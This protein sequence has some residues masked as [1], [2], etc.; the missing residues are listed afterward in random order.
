MYEAHRL[1]GMDKNLTYKGLEMMRKHIGWVTSVVAF[2]FILADSVFAAELFRVI[3]VR[4]GPVEKPAR[5]FVSISLDRIKA[6]GAEVFTGARVTIL[7]MGDPL[8]QLAKV[9]E[10]VAKLK[11]QLK[12][13]KHPGVEFVSETV[14]PA[15]DERG[16]AS[17]FL[18]VV[19]K[20][21]RSHIRKDESTEVV[22]IQ[23]VPIVTEAAPGDGMHPENY[24]VCGVAF[25][26]VQIQ[27]NRFLITGGLINPDESGGAD[28]L[29][30][31]AAALMAP[32]T[33][34]EDSS[35]STP[36][37]PRQED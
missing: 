29:F 4:S 11:E 24:F 21:S 6:Q 26:P 13:G 35:T 23:G 31:V 32:S 28:A 25:V 3:P 20:L 5:S 37:D 30:G 14:V 27:F 36:I 12:G 34:P 2:G 17:D 19:V 16:Q 10:A 33:E 7:Y 1:Q 15:G 9:R 8:N 18:A 22:S